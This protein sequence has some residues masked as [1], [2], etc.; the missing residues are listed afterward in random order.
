M[1][2]RSSAN[3]CGQQKTQMLLEY[4]RVAD[5]MTKIITAWQKV[6][7]ELFLSEGEVLA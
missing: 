6:R 4:T 7:R 1:D 2:C 3:G 5:E